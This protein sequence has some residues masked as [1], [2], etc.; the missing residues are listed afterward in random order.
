MEPAENSPEI[1]EGSL[2][3]SLMAWNETTLAE[4]GA[5][6]LLSLEDVEKL[7]TC[8]P[9]ISHAFNK[10]QMFRTQTEMVVSV[11]NDVKFPTPD[12]KYWQSIREMNVMVENLIMLGFNFKRK[13][14]DLK[15]KEHQLDTL[16]CIDS[17]DPAT[18]P[19]QI[20]RERLI[21]D[22]EQARFEIAV[23]Q[24]EAHHRIREVD[25]WRK[26]QLDLAPK[27]AAGTDDVDNHQLLSYAIRFLREYQISV[28]TGVEKGGGVEAIQNQKAHVITTLRVIHD[29]GL[30]QQLIAILSQDTRLFNFLQR[31]EIIKVEK[32]KT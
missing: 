5:S 19:S 18:I 17:P 12:A 10:T 11:L 26:I 32:K 1:K 21:V 29:R 4:L 23:I 27:V 22:V 9:A 8:A 31:K 16:D 28:E 6:S 3:T 15:E 20:A 14:L 2:D 30:T 24:R 7:K 13:V 25:L